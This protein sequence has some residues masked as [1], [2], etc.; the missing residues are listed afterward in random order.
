MF[1]GENDPRLSVRSNT[2]RSPNDAQRFSERP[3]PVKQLGVQSIPEDV[4]IRRTTI[5]NKM[6]P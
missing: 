4:A 2:L 6:T 1:A 5:V 3:V